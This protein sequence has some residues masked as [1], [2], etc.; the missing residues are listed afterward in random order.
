MISRRRCGRRFSP[1]AVLVAA[2]VCLL[3]VTSL[4]GGMLQGALRARRQ[5]H[6]ERDLRQTE[7]LLQAG[8]ERGVFRLTNEDDYRGETWNIPAE[9]L[10]RQGA[11]RVLVE[12][13]RQTEG[14]PWRLYVVAEYPVGGEMSIRRSRT[15]SIKSSTSQDQE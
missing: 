8:L 11:G 10:H 6:V 15:V 2:L 7:L 14:E 1:G 5:L 9:A 3:I 13:S 4:V 12:A